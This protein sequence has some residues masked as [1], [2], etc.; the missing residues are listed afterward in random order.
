VTVKSLSIA[1]GV[2]RPGFQL[3]SLFEDARI[4]AY[5]PCAL[6]DQLHA[7]IW[8]YIPLVFVSILLVAIRAAVTPPYHKKLGARHARSLTLPTHYAISKPL[9]A[10]SHRQRY[11]L[12]VAEDIWDVAWPPLA[13]YAIIAVMTLVL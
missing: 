7:Y 12:R 8:V 4:S 2:R 3:L 13:V 5:R 1:M 9:L 11:S 6:P 10:L